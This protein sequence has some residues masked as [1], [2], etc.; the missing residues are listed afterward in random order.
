MDRYGYYQGTTN[1]EFAYAMF[2]WLLA[3]VIVYGAVAG[4]IYLDQRDNIRARK[5]AKRD[6]AAKAKP[7]G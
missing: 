2:V 4:L 6:A 1:A 5:D 3:M 7:R